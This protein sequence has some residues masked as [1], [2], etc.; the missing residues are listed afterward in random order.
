[1]FDGRIAEDFK[2]NTGTWVSVGPLR[3]SLLQ[4]LAPLAFD[5]VIAGL[6]RDYVS[7][8]IL[9]DVAACSKEL[10]AAE[11]L[12]QQELARDLRLLQ[13]VVQRLAA[14]AGAH[15]GST[16]RVRR[17][18]IVPEPPSLDR[19]EITDKGSINQHLMLQRWQG[20]IDELYREK[21]SAQ[22]AVVD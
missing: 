9:P 17:A 20:L 6:N 22:V 15:G 2:L 11:P 4:C 10:G 7:L 21:P 1:V 13:R 16:M 3:A 5:V 18:L 19:G 8:L 12:R 14:H